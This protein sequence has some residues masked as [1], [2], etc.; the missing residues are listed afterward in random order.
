MQVLRQG[1]IWMAM[2]GTA[3][4]EPVPPPPANFSGAQYIDGHGCVYIRDGR[5]WIPRYDDRGAEI[6]GFPPS[7]EARRTDPDTRN[8]LAPAEAPPEPSAEQQLYEQLAGELRQ[9][10]FAV[11]PGPRQE[12]K[13]PGLPKKQDPVAQELNAVVTAMP[14][15]Q[16]GIAA[17][18]GAGSDL[19]AVLGYRPADD[20][21]PLLGGD[22][23]Q[24]MCLGM[25]APTPEERILDGARLPVASGETAVAP[26]A[27][28][29]KAAT[30]TVEE[31]VVADRRRAPA[32]A[33]QPRSSAASGARYGA[34]GAS[35]TADRREPTPA[36]KAPAVE[37]IPASARYVQIGGFRDDSN[38]VAALRKLAGMGYPT[39][40]TYARRDNSTLRV[41][42][43]GPF[44]DRQALIEALNRLRASGYPRAAAR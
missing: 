6:C 3:L 44:S 24:G 7:L 17:A 30:A 18:T 35:L 20:T 39:A 23:T 37:M 27:A 32:T 38:A 43:A 28:P 40:Q 34:A 42:M 12:L 8:V 5:D 15:L 9:G 33:V 14:A 41:I 31:N 16:A 13:D 19:C 22:V 11:D 1:V 10:E 29:A 36:P 21:T 26:Q 25:R 4:A 2:A